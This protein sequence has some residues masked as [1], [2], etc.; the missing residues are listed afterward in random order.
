M[1]SP[2]NQHCANCYGTLSF[3]IGGGGR[4][5]KIVGIVTEVE[6]NKVPQ[7]VQGRS[8]GWVWGKAAKILSN[9]INLKA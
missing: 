3:P 8:P 7:R 9:I 5:V 1:A 2:G 4:S 6:N